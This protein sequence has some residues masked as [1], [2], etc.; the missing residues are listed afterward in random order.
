MKRI[1]LA[2]AAVAALGGTANAGDK[3]DLVYTSTLMSFSGR[4]CPRVRSCNRSKE[5]AESAYA[6]E[7][8]SDPQTMERANR[9][10]ADELG[11]KGLKKFCADLK[12]S[13]RFSEE[14]LK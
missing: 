1:A 13:A 8:K 10:V 2:L 12:K 9:Q 7:M 6:D 5:I 11:R 4:Y 3:A 14:N